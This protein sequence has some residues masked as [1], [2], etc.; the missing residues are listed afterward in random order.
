MTE[1]LSAHTHTQCRRI[2][3]SLMYHNDRASTCDKGPDDTD[4]AKVSTGASF[5]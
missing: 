2:L 4:T 1:Q 5:R 3:I